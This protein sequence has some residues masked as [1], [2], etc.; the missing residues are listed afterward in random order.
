MD[1][2]MLMAASAGALRAPDTRKGQAVSGPVPFRAPASPEPSA[3]TVTIAAKSHVTVG[4]V[5]LFGD[6]AAKISSKAGWDTADPLICALA[7]VSRVARGVCD[8]E[9]ALAKVDLSEPTLSVTVR[10]P[11]LKREIPES[12]LEN[13]SGLLEGLRFSLVSTGNRSEY[14]IG[15][16]NEEGIRSAKLPALLQNLAKAVELTD[17]TKPKLRLV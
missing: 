11:T 4:P 9:I 2:K 6:M 5:G 1:P 13:V 7:E 12:L 10:M 14:V 8:V 15:L 17:E 3:Y 16:A